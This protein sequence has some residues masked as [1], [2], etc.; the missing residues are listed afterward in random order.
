MRRIEHLF[1]ATIAI[2]LVGD[3]FTGIPDQGIIFWRDNTLRAKI[4]AFL[5]RFSKSRQFS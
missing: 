1:A 3:I 5:A 4:S 2:Q